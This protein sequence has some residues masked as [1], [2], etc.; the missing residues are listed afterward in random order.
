MAKAYDYPEKVIEWYYADKK[1]LESYEMAALEDEV[2][3]KLRST[4]KIELKSI[5]YDDALKVER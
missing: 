5:S 4:A 3:E 1:R 2:V